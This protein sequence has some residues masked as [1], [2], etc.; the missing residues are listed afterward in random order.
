MGGFLAA[1]HPAAVSTTLVGWGRSVV[2]GA[3]QAAA[4]AVAT[5]DA[6]AVRLSRRLLVNQ[7]FAHGE[8][9]HLK[10]TCCTGN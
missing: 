7:V 10:P 3:A 9:T 2:C 5:A 1:P 4:T 8:M 6:A